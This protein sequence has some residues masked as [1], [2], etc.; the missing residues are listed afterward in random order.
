MSNDEVLE[1]H[2]KVV[3]VLA[4]TSSMFLASSSDDIWNAGAY[5]AE[6]D[7]FR[8]TF[9]LESGGTTLR[10]LLARPTAAVVIAPNGPYQPF[11]QGRG[12]VSV[13]D[14]AG[15]QATIDA[16][17]AK[18]PLA[19]PLIEGAPVEA[20]DLRVSMWRVTDVT[21]GWLPGK[22]LTPDDLQARAS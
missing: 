12:E 2:R 21:A 4:G 16:L 22:V 18:E 15:K 6:L 20:V 3:D 7:P 9:V 14:A 11:L 5:Y 17:V 8:L 13:R 1:I 19:K 10:N